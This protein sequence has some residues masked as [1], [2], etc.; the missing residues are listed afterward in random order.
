MQQRDSGSG[1]APHLRNRLGFFGGHG[2]PGESAAA[3]AVRELH[4]ELELPMDPSRLE[5]MGLFRK[6][7]DLHGDNNYVN[8]FR[9]HEPVDPQTLTVHEGAGYALVTAA[10]ADSFKFTPFAAYMVG[11]LLHHD[12]RVE[13]FRIKSGPHAV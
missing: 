8:F 5:F 1:G 11:F 3:A 9:Y 6:R 4:E 12:R 13:E 10:N 7:T 2:E